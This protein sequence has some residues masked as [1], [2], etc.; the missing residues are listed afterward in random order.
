MRLVDSGMIEAKEKIRVV[1]ELGEERREEDRVLKKKNTF[2]NF[3]DSAESTKHNYT[4]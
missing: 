2:N 1:S 3:F 4:E